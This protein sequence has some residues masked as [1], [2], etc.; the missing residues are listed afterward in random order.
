VIDL[1]SRRGREA[2]RQFSLS[3]MLLAFDYDGTLA[4]IVTR[5]ER[6]ELRIRTR[7]L[8]EAVARRYPVAVVSGRA[9][10]DA[11]AR[12]RGVGVKLVIGTHGIEPFH[13]TDELA[14]V[15][16]RWADLLR[17]CLTSLEGVEIEDKVFSIAVHYRRSRRRAHARRAILAATASLKGVRILEGKMVVDILPEGAPHK[18]MALERARRQLGCETVVYVGDDA[19]DEDVFSFDQRARF[20]GVRVG[21]RRSSAAPYFLRNQPA[22]DDLLAALIQFRTAGKAAAPAG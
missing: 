12:L 9:C 18:G 1:L 2:L 20:L 21:R 14:R 16:R 3:G 11:R 5:P 13:A 17:A 22:V 19:T 4:P 6:A 15:V 8:L 7:R 10:E